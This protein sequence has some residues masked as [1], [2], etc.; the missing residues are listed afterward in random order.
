MNYETIKYF[1]NEKYEATNYEKSIEKYQLENQKIMY[2]LLMEHL[3][4]KIFYIFFL[5]A[6]R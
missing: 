6:K 3:L 4:V 2:L 5:A 1:N